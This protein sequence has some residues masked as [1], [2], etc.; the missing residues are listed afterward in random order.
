MRK[1]ALFCV[2][3]LAGC[4]APEAEIG[5]LSEQDLAEDART[6][7]AVPGPEAQA[8]AESGG[9]LARLLGGNAPKAEAAD[10]PE[11][12]EAGASV[13]TA[14]LTPPETYG[15]T[16]EVERTPQRRGLFGLL[17]GGGSDTPAEGATSE[18]APGTVL[19]YGKVARICGLS[20]R[21]MG[22]R[23]ETLPEGRGRYAL[24]DSA[25]GSTALRSFYLT[26]F[27]DGCARQFSAAVAV[28]AGAESH[29]Q[30]RY[31]LPAEVQPYSTTDKA[32]EDLKSRVCRV[33]R[34]KPCGTRI[35][36]LERDTVFV[37]IYER[38]GSNAQWNTVLVHDGA[39][40][41]QDRKGG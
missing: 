21:Q 39:V 8:E 29:E 28:L 17:G 13:E 11:D 4:G 37:S 14:S 7:G 20:D 32:Y 36:R 22:K 16:R 9:F 30:L 33:G 27:D 3:A 38:F 31:G 40:V 23:V 12:A 41:A 1:I 15:A 35:N 2:L 18:V 25:P 10:N 34:G 19:P 26:G 24:Y 5:R 6:M